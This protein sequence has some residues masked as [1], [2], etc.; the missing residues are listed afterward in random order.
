MDTAAST[1][2]CVGDESE[3]WLSQY[4][5]RQRVGWS[6]FQPHPLTQ[7]VLTPVLYFQPGLTFSIK[8]RH[9]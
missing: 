7:V 8:G 4:H 2:F 5:P 6:A 3:R 1:G 9:L